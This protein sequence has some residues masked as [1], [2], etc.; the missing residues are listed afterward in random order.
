MSNALWNAIFL[1]LGAALSHVSQWL[2]DRSKESTDA[3]R[4]RREA[5]VDW[6]AALHTARSRGEA[7]YRLLELHLNGISPAQDLR[8]P[9]QDVVD[10]IADLYRSLYR[11]RLMEP[12]PEICDVLAIITGN[13]TP[14]RG[15]SEKMLNIC[16]YKPEATQADIE[17]FRGDCKTILSGLSELELVAERLFELVRG[18]LQH[19][20]KAV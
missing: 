16:Q 5:Y 17:G 4:E 20:H 18:Y 15:T 13:L 12:M 14:L 3:L 11:A 1:I 7:F 2:I 6:F 19:G 9:V 10:A 8:G